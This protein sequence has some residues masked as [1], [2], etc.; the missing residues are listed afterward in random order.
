LFFI[1][2]YSILA[3]REH[4]RSTYLVLWDNR[5]ALHRRDPFDPNLR[6]VMH[7]TQLKG[8]KPF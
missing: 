1:S 5:C 2:R 7:C 3:L 6:R 8:D 4:Q